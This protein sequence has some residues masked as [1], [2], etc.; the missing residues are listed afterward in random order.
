[1][2]SA[3]LLSST[4]TAKI[5]DEGQRIRVKKDDFVKENEAE[6]SGM[7]TDLS[8]FRFICLFSCSFHG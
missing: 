3:P 4:D 2:G 7:Q 8:K 6:G 1:M 5:R